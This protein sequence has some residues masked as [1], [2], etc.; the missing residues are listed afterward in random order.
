MAKKIQLS[1]FCKQLLTFLRRFF[2]MLPPS[3]P[4]RGAQRAFSMKKE[5]LDLAV[6]ANK[7]ACHLVKHLQMGFL[8]ICILCYK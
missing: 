8:I 7:Y 4:W 3:P 6:V 5:G 2:R 1:E